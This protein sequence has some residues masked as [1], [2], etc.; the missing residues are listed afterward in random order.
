MV[1]C[2]TYVPNAN[3]WL[4]CLQ[5]N[6]CTKCQCY[7]QLKPHNC[8]TSQSQRQYLSHNFSTS[9]C[10]RWSLPDSCTTSQGVPT[11]IF[12]HAEALGIR[13]PHILVIRVMFR[14]HNHP[15]SNCKQCVVIIFVFYF[16]LTL[17]DTAK[18]TC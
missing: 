12:H 5:Q 7:R 3:V 10:P 13:L 18:I 14:G 9:Q 6:N 15:V 2:M 1:R 16:K 17:L 8:T 4:K 11:W